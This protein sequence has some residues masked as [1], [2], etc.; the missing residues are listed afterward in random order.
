[1][2]PILYNENPPTKAENGLYAYVIHNEFEIRGFFGEYFFLSNGKK[3]PILDIEN[4]NLVYPFSENAYQAA[5][6]ESIEIR[7]KFQEIDFR[8][9]ITLAWEL[10]EYIKSDWQ[11]IKLTEMKRILTQKFQNEILQKRLKDT[12]NRYLEETNHWKD[13]YWGVCDGI[14]GNN[15]GKTLMEIRNLI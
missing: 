11:N 1:M 4:E 7:S 2:K 15:L 8:Q 14:G 13:T 6:F 9:S 12:K 10:R 3:S 5:K